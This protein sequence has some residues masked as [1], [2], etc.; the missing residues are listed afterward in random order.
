MKGICFMS[1]QFGI[2]L[3]QGWTVDLASMK[4]PVEAYEAMTRVVQT[5]EFLTTLRNAF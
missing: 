3:P 2:S 5:A 1:L 4:D